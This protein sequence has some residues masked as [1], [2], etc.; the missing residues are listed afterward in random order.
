MEFP[1]HRKTLENR[2]DLELLIH[3]LYS[4]LMVD[5]Q[6]GK[7][8]TEV[9]QLDLAI[10]LPRIVSF[11]DNLLFQATDY[12]GD[13]MATHIHLHR[14]HPLTANDFEV[15]LAHFDASMDENFEGEVAERA[16]Q[17]ARSIAMLMQIKLQRDI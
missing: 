12:Q 17:R 14:L 5:P 7:L 2:K 9:V 11:W 16:K 15:W 13:P 4:R 8:F 1:I 6:I 10:H 3:R